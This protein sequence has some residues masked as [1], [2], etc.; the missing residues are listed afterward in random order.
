MSSAILLAA[1]GN[2]N[3]T[4]SEMSGAVEVKSE[5]AEIDEKMH[6]FAVAQIVGADEYVDGLFYEG[7]R[8]KYKGR[9][10]NDGTLP[11]SFEDLK[12]YFQMRN[13]GN[14]YEIWRTNLYEPEG[15]LLYVIRYH[16]EPN[17]T[18]YASPFLAEKI[19]GQWEIRYDINRSFH[20]PHFEANFKRGKLTGSGI[21]RLNDLYP[22]YATEVVSQKQTSAYFETLTDVKRQEI[23]QHIDTREAY[24][25]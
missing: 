13:T 20:S 23:Q 11:S 14:N 16:H 9:I 12:Y 8:D 5:Y 17:D 25:D 3:E 21:V 7:D 24:Y 19:D 1:C 10:V 18:K 22:D 4:A 15:F 6:E 2:E